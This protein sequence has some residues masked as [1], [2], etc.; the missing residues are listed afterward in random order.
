MVGARNLAKGLSDKGYGEYTKNLKSDTGNLDLK[1]ADIV[2]ISDHHVWISLGT[3]DDGSVVIAHCTPS[4]SRTNNPGGG[5]QISAI[6]DSTDCEA[7][8]LAKKYMSKYYPKW[9][10]RYPIYL[11]DP[12]VYLAVDKGNAGRFRWSDN[13]LLDPERITDMTP[14]EVLKLLFNENDISENTQSSEN[15]QSVKVSAVPKTGDKWL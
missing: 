15:V 7:Y 14:E 13:C 11:T 12:N 1:P 6:G 5:V 8:R 9:Y 2:S 3:C 4:K 10:D